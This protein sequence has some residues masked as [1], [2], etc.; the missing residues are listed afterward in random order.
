MSIGS[1]YET[2]ISF[3]VVIREKSRKK[4]RHSNSNVSGKNFSVRGGI[5]TYENLLYQILSTSP[6]TWLGNPRILKKEHRDA[7]S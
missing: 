2:K 6:L 4:N 5:R 3:L 1:Y 7:R